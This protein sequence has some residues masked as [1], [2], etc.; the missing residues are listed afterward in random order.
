VLATHHGD[1][2]MF[3]V[4]RLA[5]SE[6][7]QIAEDAVNQPMLDRLAGSRRVHDSL[8]GGGP[9]VP[10]GS[11]TYTIEAGPGFT[12]LSAVWMLVNTN[13]AF[14][15]LDSIQLPRSGEE[16]V[17]VGAYDAGSEENTELFEHIPGPCCMNPLQRVPTSEPIRRHPGISGHGDLDPL[18]YGWD[19]PVARVTIRRAD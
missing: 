5:S 11:A 13:D 8:A 15:G 14:S 7:A 9:I 12:R 1:L 10:G 18:T 16:V 19:G 2:A 4:G 6:L 3:R 17:W